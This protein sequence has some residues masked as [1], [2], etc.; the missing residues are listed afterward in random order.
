MTELCRLLPWDSAHFGFGV[1]RLQRSRLQP[2][3]AGR[4]LEWCRQREIR[5]L[6]FLADADDAQTAW[7]AAEYGF[8]FVDARLTLE[9]SLQAPGPL[10]EK[11]SGT[12]VRPF[13]QKDLDAL[14]AIARISHHDS[15]FYYDPNFPGPACDALYEAWIKQSCQGQSDLVLVAESEGRPAG[16]L[17]I[18]LV[19][20]TT[21]QI[22]LIAVAEASRGRGLGDS[23]LRAGLCWMREQGR[24]RS[25]VVTQGRNVGA[26]RLYER[27]GFLT[28]SVQWWYHRWFL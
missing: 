9:R 16:Y 20:D 19:D 23:L 7:L 11:S 21:A 2:E 26:T 12:L 18:E 13:R 14:Q 4:A 27:L 1:A 8:R 22:G 25:I 5:C 3:E 6:Y 17:T 28:R 24:Q 10:A 15:R